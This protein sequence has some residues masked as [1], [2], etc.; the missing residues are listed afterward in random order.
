MLLGLGGSHIC[1]QDFLRLLPEEQKK[2]VEELIEKKTILLDLYDVLGF[3]AWG[4]ENPKDTTASEEAKSPKDSPAETLATPSKKLVNPYE[5][6]TTW[7]QR[8]VLSFA[9]IPLNLPLARSESTGSGTHWRGDKYPEFFL[10]Q[11]L[12]CT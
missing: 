1:F 6:I 11:T 9:F 7:S 12:N 3:C 5:K 8:A 10:G 4:R 2:K